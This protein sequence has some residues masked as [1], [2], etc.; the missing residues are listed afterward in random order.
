MVGGDSY[1]A[2]EKPQEEQTLSAQISEGID[3]DNP[4]SEVPQA[5]VFETDTNPF[6][7][8]GF[9]NPFE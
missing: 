7:D 2:V 4:A 5:N 9:K 6:S 8:D 3:V 1:T